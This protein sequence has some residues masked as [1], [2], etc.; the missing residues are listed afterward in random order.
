MTPTVKEYM[1]S[2]FFDSDKWRLK[3]GAPDELKKE[4]EDDNNTEEWELFYR[5]K[6]PEMKAPYYKWNG[7]IVE[8][9]ELENFDDV[10]DTKRGVG[11]LVLKDGKI[12][13]GVRTTP[14]HYGEVCGPGGHV[15]DGESD[16]EAAVRETQE[17]FGLTPNTLVKLEDGLYLCTDYSGDVISPDGEMRSPEF[18]SLD[19]IKDIAGLC[20]PPF[21]YSVKVLIDY[22][23]DVDREDKTDWITVNGNHIPI[24]SETKEPKGG[25]QKALGKGGN[26]TKRNKVLEV[27]EA[28]KAVT[29]KCK[30]SFHPESIA[31]VKKT[32]SLSFADAGSKA[33]PGYALNDYEHTH[34]C[35]SSIYACSMLRRGYKVE[36]LG[37]N[38]YSWMLSIHPNY[39]YIDPDTGK[40]PKMKTLNGDNG[41]ERYKSLLGMT[42]IGEEYALTYESPIGKGKFEGHAI[43]VGVSDDGKLELYDSMKH[44]SI[45][46]PI[47]FLHNKRKLRIFRTDN[48]DFNEDVVNHIVKRREE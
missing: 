28:A 8:R 40:P 46:D 32:E 3:D 45:E 39:G 5:E 35:Q 29:G 27:K 18:R 23:S 48:C 30:H 38:E 19:E 41:N 13:T 21:A 1:K 14:F 10:G 44:K 26:G 22:L 2:E 17:E 12:L 33:N 11:I 20:F 9:S 25:Q 4:F 31:G 16:E 47:K 36:A 24:D 15:K 7:E 42:K 43:N 37:K 6:Y 34:N